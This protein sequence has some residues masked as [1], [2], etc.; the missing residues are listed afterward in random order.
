M[1][2]PR[3]VRFGI[4]GL[5][6]IAA[7]HAKAIQS[8]QHAKLIAAYSR[9]ETNRRKFNDLFQV[10]VC[11]SCSELL[12][13]PELEA[14]VIC[15]PSGTHLEYGKK[16]AEAGKH[17]IVEKPIEVT[18]ARGRELIEACKQNG[19]KLAVI[20]Q[21]R[22][23]DAAIKMK[24][25][26]ENGVIG[27]PVMV[28]AAVKWF[29]NQAYYEESE[30]R[31][32]YALDG[33]GAV[34]N[35]AIH[36]I[37]LLI[38]LLGDIHHIAAIKATLTHPQIEAEDN[39]VAV[40]HFKSGA[41][42]VFEASTSVIPAQPRLIEI[43]GT[44]GTATLEDDRFTLMVGEKNQS[45]QSELSRGGAGASDPLAGLQANLHAK[46]YSQIVHEILNN[47]T[48]DVTGEEALLSLAAAEAIYRSAADNKFVKPFVKDLT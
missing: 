9:T 26:L 18:V 44:R 22:F 4:A 14:V 25:T 33:G 32:T 45:D 43:N 8:L 12:S 27:K 3:M 24:Q 16:V 29:R 47:G 39:A 19:V 7:T 23:L 40:I 6:S 11:H 2:E 30:W 42:G 28:R 21:N 41:I 31:G 48:P 17:V 35:Q 36:T 37:D 34:I 13:H 15:T 10:P 5:G 46:Q 20:Y 1:S 38:W